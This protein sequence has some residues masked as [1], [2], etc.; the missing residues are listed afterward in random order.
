VTEEMMAERRQLF[1][2]EMARIREQERRLPE[3]ARALLTSP[4]PQRAYAPGAAARPIVVSRPPAV[5]FAFMVLCLVLIIPIWG[6]IRHQVAL[7]VSSRGSGP[8]GSQGPDSPEWRLARLQRFRIFFGLPDIVAV[9][10]DQNGMNLILEPKLS[11]ASVLAQAERIK[12]LLMGHTFPP[13]GPQTERIGVC[14][15]DPPCPVAVIHIPG[16]GNIWYVT[17]GNRIVK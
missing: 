7:Q 3:D 8:L 6:Y 9:N 16:P 2:E 1:L 17:D 14:S 4:P 11:H 10:H 13:R 5:P 15:G 12:V